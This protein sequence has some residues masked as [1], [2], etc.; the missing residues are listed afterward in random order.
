MGGFVHL[1]VASSFSAHYGASWPEDLVA[2]AAADGAD[3]AACVDR[4]GLYGAVKHVSACRLHGLSPI[5]G[6]NLQV[7]EDLPDGDSV[8]RG[9]VVLLA[10]GSAAGYAALCRAVSAAHLRDTGSGPRLRLS[11]LV[12]LACPAGVRAV[13]SGAVEPALFVL[14]GPESDIG[15]AAATRRYARARG[16]L[17]G[18]RAVLGT[19]PLRIEVVSHL[20]PPGE[21]LSTAHAARMLAIAEDCSVAPVLTNMVRFAQED[22]ATTADV[23]DAVRV[24]SSLQVTETLQPNGQGWLKP[25]RTMERLAGEICAASSA[26][27]SGPVALLEHTRTLAQRC[28]VDPEEH[29]SFRV[30]KVPEARVLGLGRQGRGTDPR[31]E[32]RQRCEVGLAARFPGLSS[33]AAAQVQGRLEHE[34]AIIED[35]GFASYFLTVAEVVAM[36]E[37]MGVR[38]AARGSGASSLV[39]HLL[40]ISAVDPIE[41]DLIFERFLSRRR[42]TLPDIDIDVESARRHEVYHRIFERFGPERTTLM[43][44]QNSYRIRG[45]VRDAG[46][47]LGLPEEEIAQIAETMWRFPARQ[48][49]EALAEKPELRT[50]AARLDSA[51]GQGRQQ[52]DLLVDLTERLDRLP[53]H[54]STHPCGII[55]GDQRLLDL[56]P[57]QPSGVD[58]LPMSQFDKHDMDPMGFLK[59]DVLGVRMQSTIAHALQEVHRTTGERIDLE[60]VDRDDEATY[61]LI[62]STHTLGCFQVESP[63]QRELVGKLVPRCFSDL[64]VDISLFRPGP[65]GSGMVTPYLERRHGFEPRRFPHP[66]LAEVL[67]ETH[68]VTIYHEQVLRLFDTMTGCGL[69]LADELRRALGGS[70][71]DGVEEFF[72]TRAAAGGYADSVIDEVWEIL[73]SFGSFGFCKAHGAA[74][75]VPTFE[76][77]WLKT[78]HPAAF[79]AGLFEHDPGMYPLRLLVAEARRLGVPLLGMDVNRSNRH[80]VLEQL[81]DP[82][83]PDEQD[84]PSAAVGIRMALTSLAGISEA[85]LDRITETQPFDSLAD[86]RDRA[87]PKRPTLRALAQVG[88]LDSLMPGGRSRRGDLIA[89]VAEKTQAKVSTSRRRE[90]A[91]QL[92]LPIADVELAALPASH[93]AP[94]QDELIADELRL[95]SIDVTG[96]VMETHRQTMDRFGVTRAEDLLTLRSGSTVRVAGIRV[97]TQTPPMASGRRVV[98]I[99]LDDG[100]GCADVAF[101]DEAQN[102]AGEILFTARLMLV[103]GTIRRTGP[104][105]VSIQACEAWDLRREDHVE[106]VSRR[107]VPQAARAAQPVRTG[108][109]SSAS[110][111]VKRRERIMNR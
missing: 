66:D 74:F 30:P 90:V 77:A 50:V 65:M 33:S 106:Q 35:L 21:P 12:E 81:E 111:S 107:R 99:S 96:H 108:S 6:V 69:A 46:L 28:L 84:R 79:L 32:L 71:Q 68:G 64:V 110:S 94:E 102:N 105:A 45:A 59:L 62:Q 37:Q 85:E 48:F 39:N 98:F 15:D 51:R 44:M 52:L 8:D 16:L 40:R 14:L 42:S 70:E 73:D 61:R 91:G 86:L 76:S 72:R 25:A 19:V 83:I 1:D 89:A 10:H 13:T 4:D 43:S 7:V 92:P 55:L 101:F 3:A 17:R 41:H 88:A 56:T 109:R 82:A 104:R 2:A 67:A 95:T 80:Y 54:I 103:E 63:G 23:L 78:H 58:G 18:W 100:T 75:A 11:Q 29:M 31:R 24:L 5:L 26:A 36:V 57:V 22:D 47:A 27:R 20:A 93:S 60:A 87:R 53:R 34:L 49:R 38:V 97:A 9:R